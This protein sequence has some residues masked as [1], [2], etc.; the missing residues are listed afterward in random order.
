M[1]RVAVAIK[2]LNRSLAVLSWLPSGIMAC[3]D[4][5]LANASARVDVLS[6]FILSRR[7]L[8]QF[9][10]SVSLL[11]L[12]GE[13]TLAQQSPLPT[14][15]VPLPS[16]D[17]LNP[18]NVDVNQLT[19]EAL[20]SIQQSQGNRPAGERS[21][22][23]RSQGGLLTRMIQAEPPVSSN[24]S[25]NLIPLAQPQQGPGQIQLQ[26]HDNL[27]HLTSRGATV[28]EVLAM[29]SSQM[30]LNIVTAED[31][32]QRVNVTLN[33]VL[34]EDALNSILSINGLVWARQNNIITISTADPEK[35]LA[36]NVQGKAIQVF[37]LNY[38]MGEDINQVILGLLSPI[39][40]SY[41]IKISKEE[42]RSA[43]EQLIVEDLPPYI[44]R[45]AQYISQVD[46]APRQVIVE[47]NILQVTLKDS[48]KNGVNF[49]QVARVSNSAVKFRTI[50]LT[51]QA[52]PTAA[53]EING[54][55][56]TGWIECLK[57][58]ND[59]KTLASPK[60][61]VL[62]GQEAKIS[63]GGKLG[64]LLTTATQ[65]AALQSVSFLDFG[66]ML[67]VLPI[68]TED[69][70]V[71]LKV[72]PQVSTARINNTSKLPESEAT[73]V[74]TNVMLYD[75]Q[76]IVIGGLIKEEKNDSQN[77]V[78]FFGDIPL[79]GRLF[80]S[81]SLAKE[82]SEIIITLLPRIAMPGDCECLDFDP[83]VVQASTP[84]MDKNLNPINRAAWEG[85]VEGAADKR[86][87][88]W[89][90][91]AHRENKKAPLAPPHAASMSLPTYEPMV[92]REKQLAPPIGFTPQGDPLGMQSNVPQP[93]VPPPMPISEPM[94]TDLPLLPAQS[95]PVQGNGRS[96][97]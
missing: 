57:S 50:G 49:D 66:V 7:W 86:K 32:N 40:K 20:G 53:M 41:V 55:D 63:V 70:R 14:R 26:V 6:S 58:T 92:P 12:S 18:L 33:G 78:P 34:L 90:W 38:A 27:V 71:L 61:A 30:G 88:W 59:T 9:V 23:E 62:N 46:V 37:T 67:T 93:I 43:R 75:G 97:Q 31:L 89:T 42:Q 13:G 96:G 10:L 80:R 52:A 28:A 8:S 68:I 69:G 87:R 74:T 47:A 85:E 73:E 65:S 95:F 11:A 17:L 45:I 83:Q 16:A 3:P 91:G 81:R 39:G 51:A 72:H 84:I 76:A 29:I 25:P 24:S 48:N 54:T 56:L 36:P 82:R 60:V 4:C 77:K 44:E 15:I 22:G 21:A 1:S 64:Y 35:K 19:R 79:V 2:K 5:G 94:L